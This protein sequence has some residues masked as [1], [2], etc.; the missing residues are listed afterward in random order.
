MTA[1][2]TPSPDTSGDMTIPRTTMQRVYDEVRTPYKYGVVLRG[3]NG[4]AVD[5]PSVFRCDDRWYMVHIVFDGK[6]YETALAGSDDL[7]RWTPL[8][9]ILGRKEGSWDA[10][11]VA[12]Y[13]ALQD[14]EWGGSCALT[15]HDG[16]CWMSYLGG[17]LRGYETDPLAI[18]LARSANPCRPVEWTRIATNPVLHPHDDYARWFERK[19]LYKSNVVRDPAKRLGSQYVMF[20]NGKCATGERIGMAVSD[21]MLQWRRY[22]TD[23]IIDNGGGISGDPQVVRMGDLWVMFYFGAFWEPKAFDTFACSR[24]LEHWTKWDGP[25][26]VE[27][28]ESWDATYAHKP[29]VLKWEGIVYHFYCA[30]GD[31]GRV[32]ALATSTDLKRGR[33]APDAGPEEDPNE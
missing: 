30:V 26:L 16:A 14:T 27:P 6:G 29:W 12:G 9:T 1:A 5:C 18:G 8:G 15:R 32:I 11:Q 28:S 17:A 7:L 22:G 2:A 24:D 25:H 33:A 31:E 10:E 23:P 20:Y 4:K 3:D 19:T 21:D 13:V